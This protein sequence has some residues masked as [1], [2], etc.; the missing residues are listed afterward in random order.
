[1]TAA[2]E[3]ALGFEW[4]AS[5]LST[6]STL[7]SLAPG[8]VWRSLAHPLSTFPYVVMVHQSGA[9]TVTF[10]GRR[11]YSDLL[12]QA[13]VEGPSS[14][15]AALL[16]AAARVDSLLTQISQTTVSGGTILACFRFQTLDIE[17]LIAGEMWSAIGGIYRLFARSA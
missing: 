14:S 1:M 17:E 2:T 15:T 16:L 9:D 4:M 5:V 11:A 12:F 8:G 3:V 7:T 6:D 10:G 13:K